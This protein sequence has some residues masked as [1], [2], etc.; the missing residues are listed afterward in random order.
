VDFKNTVIIMTS[1]VGSEAWSEQRERRPTTFNASRSTR[2]APR[3]PRVPESGGRDHYFP[4][5][6]VEH[7]RK[8]VEIQLARVQKRLVSRTSR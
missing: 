5:L 4:G 1:N 6:S 7:I 2:Y 8:I 3:S